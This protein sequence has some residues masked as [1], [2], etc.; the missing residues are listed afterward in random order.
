M[1]EKII[2]SALIAA[3]GVVV[4]VLPL[5]TAEAADWVLNQDPVDWRTSGAMVITAIGTWAVNVAR[6][7]ITQDEHGDS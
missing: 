1:K 6:L 5:L 2:R 7:Y 3:G 4:T